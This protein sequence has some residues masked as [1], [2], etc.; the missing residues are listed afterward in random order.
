MSITELSFSEALHK[1]ENLQINKSKRT[2]T[3]H[4]KT[5]ISDSDSIY[6]YLKT[7]VPWVD[8]IKNRK[9]LITRLAYAGGNSVLDTYIE[10]LIITALQ[11]IHNLEESKDCEY[12]LLGT[13]INYYR[14]GNDYLPKHSH[15]GTLQFII[16]LGTTRVLTV[17]SKSYSLQSGDCMLFGS[18]SHGIVQD[19][20]IT[21]GRISIACFLKRV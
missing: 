9:K 15:P 14:D 5:I 2:L 21:D 11:K 18:S 8:G 12:L 16:S 3:K 17:G 4:Y 13:Y 19:S 7:N 1:L 6:T 20:T 10:N